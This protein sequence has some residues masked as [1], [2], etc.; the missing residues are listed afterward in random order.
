MGQEVDLNF[1]GSATHHRTAALQFQKGRLL[2]VNHLGFI[3]LLNKIGSTG[4]QNIQNISSPILDMALNMAAQ[5]ATDIKQRL[6]V[7]K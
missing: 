7:N 2:N 5:F 4:V 6:G 3:V 1:I